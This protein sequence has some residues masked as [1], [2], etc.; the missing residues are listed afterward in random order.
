MA[1]RNDETAAHLAAK[2]L[3]QHSREKKN[4][5]PPPACSVWEAKNFSVPPARPVINAEGATLSE[6][7]GPG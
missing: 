6:D 2:G 3:Q 5:S 7:W 1:R 4:L